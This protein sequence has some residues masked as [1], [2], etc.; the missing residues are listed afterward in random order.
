[1]GHIYLFL[2]ADHFLR[3]ASLP[4]S[5]LETTGQRF[6]VPHAP[7]SDSSPAF[8]LLTPV[9]VPRLLGGVSAARARLLLDV[10]RNFATAAAGRVGLVVPLSER[11]G[12]L[13]LLRQ[14][15]NPKGQSV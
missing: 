1:M 8:G 15:P 5:V 9:V 3:L 13:R 12:T 6:H 11:C 2:A 10:K 14:E 7:S 4:K